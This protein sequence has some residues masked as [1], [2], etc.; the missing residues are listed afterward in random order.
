MIQRLETKE[1]YSLL[2]E[3]SARAELIWDD[4][5]DIMTNKEVVEVQVKKVTNKKLYC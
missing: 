5:F 2:S 3:S 4:L 1:G